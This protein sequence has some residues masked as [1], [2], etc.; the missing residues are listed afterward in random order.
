MFSDVAGGQ[1]GV[2][3]TP[4]FT[5]TWGDG[6]IDADPLFIDPVSLD[7]TLF[8]GSPCI[9]AGH[10]WH[11]P[12]DCGDL[13]GDAD[14]GELTPLDRNGDPRFADVV[15]TADTGCGVPPVDMGAAEFQGTPGPNPLKIGDIDG[16]GTVG[17]NDFLSLLALWRPCA[18]ACCVADLDLDGNVGIV[19]F[20]LLL[21]NWG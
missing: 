10:T 8:S 21:G 19:D 14:T 5:L 16:D 3:V 7:F 18:T 4:G 15:A 11:V 17:I 6:N 12:Q 2:F 1:V 20:L 13:D 9:D